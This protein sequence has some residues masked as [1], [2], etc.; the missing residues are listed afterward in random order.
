MANVSWYGGPSIRAQRWPLNDAES[1]AQPLV[2]G[3]LGTNPEGFGP[4]LERY[5]LGSTGNPPSPCSV[6]QLQSLCSWDCSSSPLKQLFE[7]SVD[8]SGNK[9][10][11]KCSGSR[12]HGTDPTPPHPCGKGRGA[13]AECQR[14]GWP[15]SPQGC[16]TLSAWFVSKPSS[17]HIAAPPAPL[18]QLHGCGMLDSGRSSAAGVIFGGIFGLFCRAPNFRYHPKLIQ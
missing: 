14:M 8:V 3:D 12:A 5:F 7:S 17:V 9:I 10:S 6:Q 2:S 18:E 16:A 4:V 15:K 1:P 13:E 11:Y